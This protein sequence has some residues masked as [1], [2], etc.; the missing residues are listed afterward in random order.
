[1]LTV[2]PLRCRYKACLDAVQ[3]QTRRE[4][5]SVLGASHNIMA[6]AEKRYNEKLDEMDASVQECNQARSNMI[7][8]VNTKFASGLKKQVSDILREDGTMVKLQI[9]LQRGRAL[10]EKVNLANT[11][12]AA[13]SEAM[14]KDLADVE[15]VAGRLNAHNLDEY[16]TRI[17]DLERRTERSLTQLRRNDFQINNRVLV[18]QGLPPLGEEFFR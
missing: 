5:D 7:N 3:E 12:V 9:D 16:R 8:D 14:K 17:E 6:A 1:M 18:L 2:L 15:A 4:Y 10:L 11:S 13:Q